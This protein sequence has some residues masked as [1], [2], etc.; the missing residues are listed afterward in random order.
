ME[1]LRALLFV[2][3]SEVIEKKV[4]KKFQKSFLVQ[5]LVLYLYII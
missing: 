1:G 2:E 4:S 5:E 3:A